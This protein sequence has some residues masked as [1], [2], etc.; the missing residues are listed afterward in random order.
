MILGETVVLRPAFHDVAREAL[1][2]P[3]K[4]LFVATKSEAPLCVE[5]SPKRE[6]HPLLEER[7]IKILDNAPVQGGIY[8]YS[9]PVSFIM[10]IVLA[11]LALCHL[12]P[13]TH[14][15]AS[16]V[17]DRVRT[18]HEEILQAREA[19]AK[20]RLEALRAVLPETISKD[21]RML[22]EEVFGNADRTVLEV[23]GYSPDQ[24]RTE[25][26][27]LAP[28]FEGDLW[29]AEL[30]SES[31]EVQE[32]LAQIVETEPHE[33]LRKARKIPG[34]EVPVALLSL[35]LTHYEGEQLAE[36]YLA[37][38]E[39]LSPQ[40]QESLEQLAKEGLGKRQ[41]ESFLI[42]KGVL[43]KD[44]QDPQFQ[45]GLA[46][47]SF[48]IDRLR[49]ANFFIHYE[50]VI[51]AIQN[52]DAEHLED[53]LQKEVRERLDQMIRSDFYRDL[54]KRHGREHPIVALIQD[55]TVALR[56][57]AKGMEELGKLGAL[58][59]S[60]VKKERGELPE[61]GQCTFL[62]D[63]LDDTISKHHWSYKI[64]SFIEKLHVLVRYPEK[65]V[66]AYL[67]HDPRTALEYNSYKIGNHD[68]AY[69]DYVYGEARMR[70]YF[71]PTP[72]GDMTFV[73]HLDA[74]KAKG[75]FH[76]QHNLEHPGFSRGD[77]ART[78]Y[79]MELEKKYPHTL[80]L[81]STPLDGKAWKLK[82]KEG[83]Y[84]TDYQT[85]KEFFLKF[86]TFAFTNRMENPVS[87]FRAL[88][89]EAHRQ[90]EG[91]EDN[92]FYFG[93]EVISDR[94]LQLAFAY[95]SEAFAGVDPQAEDKKRLTR[96]LEVG[97]L[98]F[99]AVGAVV[100]TLEDLPREV[101]EER[102]MQATFGQACKLDIDRGIVMNVMTRVY[103]HLLS[104]ENL[105]EQAI[106]EII[107]T[108]IGRAEMVSGRTIIA[109][110][111]Q[112]LSDALRLIGKNERSVK[113]ALRNFLHTGFG[114]NL[115]ASVRYQSSS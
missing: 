19:L 52:P 20:N 59:H 29:R 30:R 3:S 37:A 82:G 5:V 53:F 77:L 47:L 17:T 76:L 65:T 14:N 106:N 42:S 38:K 12:L 72:T 1:Y 109:D 41:L 70:G 85:V 26:Q 2:F 56:T 7:Q 94:Q 16:R 22:V 62:A 107:G 102:L 15:L 40:I 98:G 95:A 61:E 64:E 31:S 9:Q 8:S 90:M 51:G 13:V 83:K 24:V 55:L 57:E 35:A 68:M 28:L 86:G 49:D 103:F 111:Y 6:E 60:K 110:R 4:P 108:V 58:Y 21:Y 63:A 25:M 81:F 93:K 112:P 66:A 48:H 84:F 114:V 73:A 23:A 69:G 33:C 74:L 78:Q 79:L 75:G 11:I 54:V 91:R 44:P 34:L 88:Q 105:T 89:G 10:S 87:S 45:A 80:R 43:G 100:K 50:S 96:A 99:M 115:P 36:S 104:G 32:A 113:N 71:G 18:H 67:S 97:V 46:Y 92:G 27:R 39:Q 101:A